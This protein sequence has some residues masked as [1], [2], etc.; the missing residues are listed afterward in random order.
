ME[1]IKLEPIESKDIIPSKKTSKTI[2]NFLP[3]SITLDK[4]N[5]TITANQCGVISSI[6][7]VYIY[8]SSSLF[9]FNNKN[10]ETLIQDNSLNINTSSLCSITFQSQIF[11][12]NRN[13]ES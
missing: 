9:I 2:E 1:K 11:F 12:K 4:E 6:G 10:L 3:K 7:L 8:T 13:V 5:S